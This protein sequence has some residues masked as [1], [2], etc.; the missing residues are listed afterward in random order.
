VQEAIESAFSQYRNSL[1][2]AEG[3]TP[4]F[5]GA[6]TDGNPFAP[7]T[8]AAV[9]AT[10]ANTAFRD[11]GVRASAR[12]ADGVDVTYGITA[13]SVGKDL[14]TA[15]QTLAQAG[16]I[17]ETPTATQMAALQQAAGE[18]DTGLGSLRTANADNGRKQAQV[19]TLT[20]RGEQRSLL[21]QG[22]IES[23]EDADLGQ[24][25]VDLAQQKTMLQA[26]YSVFSQ[27]AN[28]SLVSFLN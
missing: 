11:D 7:D 18:L 5:G 19:E 14:Y 9:A 22:V 12:V 28:L 15:F 20:T 17:G 2:S 26:S 1:N 23:N 21:L 25:A 27:L 24:V 6:Q 8:L 3:G 13:S 10:P 16:T 4:L